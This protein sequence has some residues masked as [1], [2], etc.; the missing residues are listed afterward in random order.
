MLPLM[1]H[2]PQSTAAFDE[3]LALLGDVRDQY[4]RSAERF[5][6]ELDVIE[7]YRYVTELLSVASELLFEG[8]PERPRFS[9]IAHPGREFLGVDPGAREQGAVG[10]GGGW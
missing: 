4:V 1:A 9:S 3:L 6:D 8:D 7:G 5:D 2:A 10:R